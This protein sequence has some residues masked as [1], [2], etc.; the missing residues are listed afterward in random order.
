MLT[1]CIKILC[2]I[3]LMMLTSNSFAQEGIGIGTASPKA[4]LDVYSDN[5][6]KG[7]ILIPRYA[8][9]DLS[10]LNLTAD[11]NSMLVYINTPNPSPL[12]G[13][14]EYM[15]SPGF[16]YYN[17]NL[18]KFIKLDGKSEKGWGINGNS[19]ITDQN[20]IGTTDQNPI[21]FKV[22]NQSF[23]AFAT[24]NNIAI[25]LE[26]LNNGLLDTSTA[27]QN[28]ALGR[29]ALTNLAI[30]RYNIGLGTR[31]LEHATNTN[32]NIALGYEALNSVN[33]ANTGFNV[34][35]GYQAL[36]NGVTILDNVSVGRSSLSNLTDGVSNIGLGRQTLE[37]AINTS[38][39]IGVGLK[40]LQNITTGDSNIAIGYNALESIT[41][42]E[43][44][45]AIGSGSSRTLATGNNNITI[46]ANNNLGSTDISN[47][48]TIGNSDHVN[49]RMWTN[50]WVTVSDQSL[51]N[52][53]TE[54]PVGLNFIRSLR[55]VEYIYN[56]ETNQSKTFGFIA[57]DVNDAVKKSNLKNVGIVQ[58]FD[59]NIL[60]LRMNDFIPVLTK[61]IQEQQTIIEKQ[62]AEIDTLKKEMDE[63][64]KLLLKK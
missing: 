64:K 14:T 48:V 25:G 19:D 22:N 56:N 7:G 39:N 31:A 41:S 58:Q 53:I 9:I 59:Q 33:G 43:R 10:E 34:A 17:H 29:F 30:G 47:N 8:A 24:K 32:Q 2:I 60:G 37:K 50:G 40:A 20:F 23:G 38:Y 52:S 18:L 16:Y 21:R 63:I 15:D 61:A 28:I 4:L 35:L 54:I 13:V 3:S 1:P 44:N 26:S 46:G 6:N 5:A 11:H 51:K 62:Q 12:P 45:I 55:P 57:Q 49:Y 42:G 27:E 36:K